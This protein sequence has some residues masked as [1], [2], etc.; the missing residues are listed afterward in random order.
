MLERAVAEGR[1]PTLGALL[2]RGVRVQLQQA[3]THP[4][5]AQVVVL[6]AVDELQ[7]AQHAGQDAARVPGLQH[8][9]VH[10]RLLPEHA[11]QAVLALLFG[12]RGAA[13]ERVGNGLSRLT[14]LTEEDAHRRAR[15]GIAHAELLADLCQR[16]SSA[17]RRKSISRGG[18][19]TR[20]PL[21][22]EGF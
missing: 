22:G 8:A 17:I 5:G 10:P 4:H 16:T 6:L 21:T 18:I 19:R 9:R 3:I 20:K 13:E 2:E 7:V 12:Q 14:L 15:V 11:V 1:A